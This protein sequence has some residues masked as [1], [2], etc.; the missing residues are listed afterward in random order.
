[1]MSFAFKMMNF[2]L[3]VINLVLEMM[4]FVLKTMNLQ[5]SAPVFA[6]ELEGV[7]EMPMLV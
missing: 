5:R 4:H 7:D 2:V 6:T 3:T 1:M